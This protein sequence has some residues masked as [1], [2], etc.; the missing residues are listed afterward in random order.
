MSK[1]E[2]I[3]DVLLENKWH[4]VYSHYRNELWPLL[5]KRHK[6]EREIALSLAYNHALAEVGLTPEDV[7][8]TIH[9]GQIGATHNYKNKQEVKRCPDNYC[10]LH[11]KNQPANAERCPRCDSQLEPATVPISASDLRK[12]FS[13]HIVGVETKDGRTVFFKEPLSRTPWADWPSEPDPK[14]GLSNESMGPES[15]RFLS[16]LL[17]AI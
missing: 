1:A 10:D 8:R 2:D 13:N 5:Q 11:F 17:D 14:S 3:V 16:G 9:G 4:K 6:L 7:E 12:K 15:K